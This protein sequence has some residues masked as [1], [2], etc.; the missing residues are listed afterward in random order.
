[1]KPA[2]SIISQLLAVSLFTY[3]SG[4]SF[5]NGNF[6]INSVPPFSCAYNLDN[7]TFNSMISNTVGYGGGGELDIIHTSCTYGT[8][9]NGNW[10]VALAYPSMGDAFTMRL[11]A[12]LVAGNTYYMCY[13]DTGADVSGCC[14]PSASVQIGVSTSSTA[15]GTVVYT[16][17]VPAINSW[18]LRSF[19]FVAPNNGQFISVEITAWRWTH[20][21]NFL[22][23][24]VP[25]CVIL[26]SSISDFNVQNKGNFTNEISW[27]AENEEQVK[28]YFIQ[29]SADG[30]HFE[31]LSLSSKPE[32]SAAGNYKMN[33]NQF[34]SGTNFY[35]IQS[36]NFDGSV[37]YSEIREIVNEW[38]SAFLSVLPNP[39]QGTFTLHHSLQN[40][41]EITRLL[42][43]DASGRVVYEKEAT[44]DEFRNMELTP[45]LKPGVYLVTL[46]NPSGSLNDRLMIVE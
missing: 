28:E 7:A 8:A 36:M 32:F 29:R 34:S 39:N 25:A 11:S 44:A 20:I 14:P 33:D 23:G 15:Q 45:M 26:G 22:I 5:L 46:H 21:D 24:N 31:T 18:N 40:S 3:V 4:Q 16:S 13:Y 42:I 35:R 38:Q 43:S 27:R 2:K 41:D 30:I 9:Q 6:E 1:M 10:Y 17:P 19:S 37:T 12:P